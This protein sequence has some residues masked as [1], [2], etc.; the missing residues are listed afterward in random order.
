MGLIDDFEPSPVVDDRGIVMQPPPPAAE[1]VEAADPV[2]GSTET[3]DPDETAEVRDDRGR[4]RGRRAQSHDARPDDLPRIKELSA[5]LRETRVEL[6]LEKG[7][8]D[9]DAVLERVYPKATPD[10]RAKH[11]K[12][13]EAQ[14]AAYQ[15]TPTKPE[16]KIPTPLPDVKASAFAEPEPQL[17]DFAAEPDPY[18]A[19]VR[20]LG[21]WDARKE[22]FEAQQKTAAEVRT[23]AEA[24]QQVEFEAIGKNWQERIAKAKDADPAWEA[25]AK[26]VDAQ[27]PSQS[28]LA[29]AILLDEDGPAMLGFLSAHQDLLDDLLLSSPPVTDATIAAMR[30]RLHSRMAGGKTGAPEPTKIAPLPRPPSPVRTSTVS[31]GADSSDPNTADLDAH[32]SARSRERRRM[33]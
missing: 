18:Q 5:T 7:L 9:V 31:L 13:V 17:A 24:A 8:R 16:P 11:R 28:V 15:P 21:R 25:A 32:I 2:N 1:V 19:H 3:A 27:I 20:A 26:K 22:V 10:E 29:F 30:R 23:K 14:V 33:H 4:Y 12:A 6:A